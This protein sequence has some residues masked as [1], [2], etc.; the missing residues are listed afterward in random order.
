MPGLFVDG[1]DVFVF[2]ILVAGTAQG[3]FVYFQVRF[4]LG[5]SVAWCQLSLLQVEELPFPVVRR[6]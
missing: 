5:S 6:R 2:P 4:A 3:L 1:E